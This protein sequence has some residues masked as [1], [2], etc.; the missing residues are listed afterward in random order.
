MLLEPSL[1]NQQA[2]LA[3]KMLLSMPLL[4]HGKFVEVS[5]NSQLWLAMKLLYSTIQL[6]HG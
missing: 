2:W 3:G 4:V 5:Q 6:A 1:H